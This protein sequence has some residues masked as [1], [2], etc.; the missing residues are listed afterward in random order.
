MMA[1][2]NG[3]EFTTDIGVISRGQAIAFA[4]IAT[5]HWVISLWG[6]VNM[7]KFA[8]ITSFLWLLFGFFCL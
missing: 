3:I 7:S 8:L 4:A 1:E 5:Y 6:G 2:Q